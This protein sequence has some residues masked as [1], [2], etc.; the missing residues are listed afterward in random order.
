ML[1][2][3]TSVADMSDYFFKNLF[4]NSSEGDSSATIVGHLP[5]WF[6][7]Q[8]VKIASNLIESKPESMS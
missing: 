3:R 8:Q 7:S 2:F 1:N 5:E 6:A 4:R